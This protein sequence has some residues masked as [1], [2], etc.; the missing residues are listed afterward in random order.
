M[1]PAVKVVQFQRRAVP[2]GF[3]VERLFADVRSALPA[4]V[5]VELGEIQG[6]VAVVAAGGGADARLTRAGPRRRLGERGGGEGEDVRPG[7]RLD[8]PLESF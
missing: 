3:S 4:D 7:G 6:L 8:R 5:G 2:G 1:A